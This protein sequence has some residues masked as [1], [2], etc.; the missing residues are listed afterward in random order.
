[1]S[2]E[3]NSISGLV[4]SVVRYAWATAL[5]NV[6]LVARRAGSLES[7]TR[8]IESHLSKEMKV[9][10]QTG[11]QLQHDFTDAMFGAFAG[12]ADL[13]RLTT[14]TAL[15]LGQC[16]AVAAAALVPPRENQVRFLELQ[17]KLEAFNLF[18]HVDLAI[19]LPATCDSLVEL[20]NRASRLGPYR[21]VWAVEG[22]G[23]HYAE[24]RERIN[25]KTESKTLPA[26]SL[27]ALHSGAGLSVACRC[28]EA[29]SPSSLD[30]QIRPVL[31]RFITLCEEASHEAYAGAA[32][33]ALG[34]ATRNL[35]PHLLADIDRHLNEIKEDLV[36]YF[37]HGVGRGLYFTPTNLLPDSE[38]SHRVVR[39]SQEEAPHELARLNIL[40]GFIWALVLVNIRHPQVL[41]TFIRDNAAELD[42]ATF[43]NAFCSAALIWRDSSPDDE[44]LNALCR[45]R[46]SDA[47]SAELWNAWITRPYSA[48]V[49]YYPM[50]RNQGLGQLFRHR[51]L[52]ELA[53]E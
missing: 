3:T 48:A 1:V 52:S 21:S 29:I 15:D 23:Y 36:G 8:A 7:V 13:P 19:D 5:F 51:S 31:D 25:L 22:I 34:L 40:S 44:A 9:I 26:S 42:E 35:Y 33:E 53:G 17:N 45:Y 47:R 2:D 39:Q 16:V 32:Y 37:W 4:K 43:A 20:V 10:F 28:L 6:S 12:D 46:S 41:E 49:K 24:S 18:T 50:L 30:F 14:K 11:N 27:V 38:R